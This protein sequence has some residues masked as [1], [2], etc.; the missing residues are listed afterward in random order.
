MERAEE[1]PGAAI[2]A[3]F[4]DLTVLGVAVDACLCVEDQ[5]R[6]G[7]VDQPQA[8]AFAALSAASFLAASWI[9]LLRVLAS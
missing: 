1:A 4:V 5:N 8:L 9:F 7:A 2:Y 3:F 6:T